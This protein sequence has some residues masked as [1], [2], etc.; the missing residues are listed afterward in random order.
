M[1]TSYI[2]LLI[3]VIQPMQDTSQG[4]LCQQPLQQLN[5]QGHCQMSQIPHPTPQIPQLLPQIPQPM[6][7]ISQPMQQIYTSAHATDISACVTARPRRSSS[8]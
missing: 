7:E 3:K 6:Q 4:Q 5:N 8:H 1:F 2:Y